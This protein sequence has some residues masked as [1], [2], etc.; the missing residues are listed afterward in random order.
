MMQAI[1]VREDK[2]QSVYDVTLPSGEVLRGLRRSS[3]TS[4][5]AFRTSA[6]LAGVYVKLHAMEKLWALRS[7]QKEAWLKLV[8][9][10]VLAGQ[11]EGQDDDQPRR[12]RRRG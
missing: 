3:L 5:A 7:A 1:R 9:D 6:A 10:A 8:A 12:G 4:Y 2:G 11:E